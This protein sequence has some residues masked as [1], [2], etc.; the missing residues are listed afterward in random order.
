LFVLTNITNSQT[1]QNLPPNPPP[2]RV[3]TY[4]EPGAYGRRDF[5]E[6]RKSE[7]SRFIRPG[8]APTSRK[9][10]FQS[11]GS[12]PLNSQSIASG[13]RVKVPSPPLFNT[14]PSTEY[15]I[16]ASVASSHAAS[17]GN[18][19]TGP[20]P[21]YNVRPSPPAPIQTHFS[22]RDSIRSGSFDVT[23][24][25]VAPVAP[26]MDHPGKLCSRCGNSALL[27]LLLSDF[28]H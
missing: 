21:A 25:L 5:S 8:A 19:L 22:D 7:D 6:R 16:P 28:C 20:N 3:N 10:S 15:F 12:L 4:P 17:G 13:S 18:T 23:T 14:T 2:L 1:S 27:S 26:M 24:G 11:Q 9:S